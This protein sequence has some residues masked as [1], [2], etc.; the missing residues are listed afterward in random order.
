MAAQFILMKSVLSNTEPVTMESLRVSLPAVPDRRGLGQYD[1]F[2]FSLQSNI[3]N[4]FP[5]RQ[6][7]CYINFYRSVEAALRKSPFR[8]GEGCL[9]KHF[10]KALH[11][12]CCHSWS[13]IV[14]TPIGDLVTRIKRRWICEAC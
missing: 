10:E 11:K 14:A 1:L 12:K 6:K 9:K 5:V 7:L 3:K 13:V 8:Q 2:V 4:E